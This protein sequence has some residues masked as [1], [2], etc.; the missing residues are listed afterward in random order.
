MLFRSVQEVHLFLEKG[1]KYKPDKVVLF[2]FINDAEPL[3]QKVK[4]G[5]LGHSHL[6]TLYWSRLHAAIERIRPS[7]NFRAYYQALYAFDQPGWRQAKE[8]LLLLK[9]VCAHRQIKLQ[10][11]ILPELHQLQPYTFQEEHA[12]IK[13]FLLE[14]NIDFLDVAPSFSKEIHPERLWVARDDAHPNAAAHRLIAEAVRDFVIASPR[15]S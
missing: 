10:V 9:T 12:L 6:I 7:R 1:L 15:P 14:Q 3:P 2:Y 11:V 4:W 13:T 5:F 8:A